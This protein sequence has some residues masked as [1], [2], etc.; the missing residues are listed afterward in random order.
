MCLQY[1]AI[2]NMKW[3]ETDGLHFLALWNELRSAVSTGCDVI[4]CWMMY[5]QKKCQASQSVLLRPWVVPRELKTMLMQN[6]EGLTRCIMG[7]VEMANYN[8][9]INSH[10]IYM[11]IKYKD[12]NLIG[13]TFNR[14]LKSCSISSSI[15]WKGE[16][17]IVRSSAWIKQASNLFKVNNTEP[18]C[19][20]IIAAYN[21]Y[22]VKSNLELG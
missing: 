10:K 8:Y 2:L 14:S 12:G 16:Q 7:D 18:E 19:F 15:N 4:F 22:E 20:T 9:Y 1:L 6:F 11:H 17:A 3:N 5:I 13:G 21:L